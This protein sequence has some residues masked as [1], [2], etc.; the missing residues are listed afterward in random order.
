MVQKPE[1]KT[2]RRVLYTKMFL[3]E[4]L[5]ELMKEKPVDKIT[6]TELCRKANIN[7]NT[8]YTH[9]YTPRDVLSEIESEFS[10]QIID[11]LQNQFTSEDIAISEMLDE[12]CRIIYE[13]QEFCKILL[14]ENGDAAFFETIINLGKGVIIE[15]WRNQGVNLSDEKMEMFFSFIVNGSVALIRKWAASDMKNSPR[16]IAEL[17]QHATYGGINGMAEWEK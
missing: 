13:K 7:R 16:E 17:I 3:K 6:P 1:T 11:S 2:D 14:S 12:I 15:G 9:Y 5:L 10:T 4:S 8:F